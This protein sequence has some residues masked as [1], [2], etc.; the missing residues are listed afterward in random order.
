MHRHYTVPYTAQ[1]QN[2]RILENGKG[3]EGFYIRVFF[4]N[5]KKN[6]NDWEITWEGIKRDINDIIGIP[7]VVQQDFGHPS[8]SEQNLFSRGFITDYIIDEKNHKVEAIARIFD[9]EIINLIR[10]K[11][12]QFSSPAVVARDS[13]SIKNING[14]DFLTRFIPLHLALV[15]NPAYGNDAEIDKICDGKSETC[16]KLLHIAALQKAETKNETCVSRKIPIIKKDNP[17]MSEDQVIAIAYSMCKENPNVATDE[18]IPALEQIPFIPKKLTASIH[19]LVSE[20]NQ[21]I[22]N[23]K[24]SEYKGEWG[25]WLNVNDIDVFKAN[26]KKIISSCCKEK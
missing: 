1:V 10:D 2:I 14:V 18:G 6:A 24:Y 17:D 4:I 5:D 22:R 11:K 21:I 13:L 7:I 9:E 23:S 12:I 19:R 25:F 15:G 20:G 3:E 16:S 26:N 8:F